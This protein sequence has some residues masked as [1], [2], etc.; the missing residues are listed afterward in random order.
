MV[1]QHIQKNT[2]TNTPQYEALTFW[3][4]N[5]RTSNHTIETSRAGI[6]FLS[7]SAVHVT[8]VRARDW[9]RN[10]SRTIMPHRTMETVW[11]NILGTRWT[12]I[13]SNNKKTVCFT[14]VYT[15]TTKRY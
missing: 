12:I 6:T 3:T 14:H 2:I 7:V 15:I 1:I 9:F 4:F 11:F 5:G 13:T 10:S 8:V